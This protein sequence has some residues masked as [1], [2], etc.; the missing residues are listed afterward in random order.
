MVGSTSPPRSFAHS[1]A[2]A[3]VAPGGDLKAGIVMHVDGGA[4][5]P[6]P[7][8]RGISWTSRAPAVRARHSGLMAAHSVPAGDNN[9]PYNQS[10]D[11]LG[12][13]PAL[14]PSSTA[15][16]SRAP[17]SVPVLAITCG[18]VGGVVALAII[19]ALV[20]VRRVRQR[21]KNMKRLTNVLG[22]ELAP[23][24]PSQLSQL[25]IDS[26]RVKF[27]G[28]R[29]VVPPRMASDL[30][31][32]LPPLSASLVSSPTSIGHPSIPLSPVRRST[33]ILGLPPAA[34]RSTIQ[35]SDPRSPTRS[36]HATVP[37]PLPTSRS[38]S[39]PQHYHD[40]RSTS[41]DTSDSHTHN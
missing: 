15:A 2:D 5:A 24:S 16:A 37:W 36:S 4:L 14:S 3:G 10:T 27:D 9:N 31:N 39:D 8:R 22:P 1:V 11:N 7:R 29:I 41:S 20:Y 17:A 38:R 25:T 21:V 19:L 35:S 32:H 28:M 13:P 12:G 33:V 26:P 23:M 30:T 6:P 34:R 18:A 40:E